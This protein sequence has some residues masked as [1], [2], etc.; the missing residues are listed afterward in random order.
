MERY[1]FAK[2]QYKK[3]GIDTDVVIERL[4]NTPISIRN[5]HCPYPC[6][7]PGIK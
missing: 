3:Y 5:A 7:E 2:E 1:E 6:Q 4:K